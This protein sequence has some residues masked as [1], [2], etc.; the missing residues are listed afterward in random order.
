M[1]LKQKRSG[2]IK[3]SGCADGRKQREHTNKED[4]SSPTVAIESVLLSF[5]ID[6]K[7]GSDVATVNLSGAFIQADMEQVVHLKKQGQ[8][9]ELLV[10]LDPKLYRKHVQTEGGKMVLYVELRKALYGTLCAALLFWRKLTEK[11][12][13]WGFTI[14]PY[15]WCVVNKTVNRKQCTIL[16][17]VDDL[18]I[19]YVDPATGGHRRDCAA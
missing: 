19:S 9:A 11:L 7:E 14:N 18:K 4:A 15:D 17:L 10:K 3:G 5:T 2:K 8:M 6:A 13:E 16:W 12:N 1:F